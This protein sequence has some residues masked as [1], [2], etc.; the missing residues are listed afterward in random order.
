VT[1][2]IERQIEY[3]LAPPT[4]VWKRPSA[5]GSSQT[6]FAAINNETVKSV[7]GDWSVTPW[8]LYGKARNAIAQGDCL[9]AQAY[10][11]AAIQRRPAHNEFHDIQLE[12]DRAR[13][14]AKRIFK[15]GATQTVELDLPADFP[16]DIFDPAREDLESSRQEILPFLL[17]YSEAWV[18]WWKLDDAVQKTAKMA[19]SSKRAERSKTTEGDLESERDQA[20]KE[21]AR[22]TNDVNDK[23]KEI[24]EK[25]VVLH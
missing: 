18:K 24:K 15:Q 16:K 21:L 17:K 6:D 9:T 13:Q 10:L 3:H 23:V 19:G 5:K 4:I 22:A 8:M 25:N 20:A 7:L 2:I 11:E 14:C 1:V 12:L